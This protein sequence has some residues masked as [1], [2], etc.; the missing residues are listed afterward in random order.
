MSRGPVKYTERVHILVTT[1]QKKHLEKVHKS[2]GFTLRQLIDAHMGKFDHD[3][4]KLEERFSIVE[5]EY[6]ALKK[7]IEE[8]RTEQKRLH[9]EKMA[10]DRLVEDAHA[11]LLGLA[12]TEHNRVDLISKKTFK[13]YADICGQTPEEL[14]AWLENELKKK[15]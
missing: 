4:A 1:E 7:R 9:D 15:T 14:Q 6:L 5:P 12:K 3:L 2:Q 8:I 13:F 11:K 10:K